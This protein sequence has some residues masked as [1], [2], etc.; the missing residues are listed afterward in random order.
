M[1]GDDVSIFFTKQLI[2]QFHGTKPGA[3]WSTLHYFWPTSSFSHA[4]AESTFQYTLLEILKKKGI[5]Q[6]LNFFFFFLKF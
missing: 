2:G 5:F 4:L 6:F 3:P 1:I